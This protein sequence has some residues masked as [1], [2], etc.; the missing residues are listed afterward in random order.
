[1]PPN[2]ISSTPDLVSL[3]PDIVSLIPNLVSLIPNL[4]SLIPN[5]FVR[6]RIKIPADRLMRQKIPN[7]YTEL[8]LF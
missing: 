6:F 8:M 7:H 3:I 4:V 1:M 5:L 2:L